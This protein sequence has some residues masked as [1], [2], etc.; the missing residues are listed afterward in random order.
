MARDAPSSAPRVAVAFLVVLGLLAGVQASGKHYSEEGIDV[1][2]GHHKA[3]YHTIKKEMW[4]IARRL[5]RL[6]GSQQHT[7][8]HTSDSRTFAQKQARLMELFES[9]A[10]SIN[11]SELAERWMHQHLDDLSEAEHMPPN[12]PPTRL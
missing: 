1:V 5:K 8:A 9:R 4:A 3:E 12:A 6:Q 7:D 10:R 11:K 2:H